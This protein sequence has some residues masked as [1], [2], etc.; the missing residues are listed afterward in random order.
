MA[1]RY[2]Y[3]RLSGGGLPGTDYSVFY[4][5][6][7]YTKTLAKRESNDADADDLTYDELTTANNGQGTLIYTPEF[8]DYILIEDNQT[9]LGCPPATSDIGNAI[10][11]S[12]DATWGTS[13]DC[14]TSGSNNI[15]V[16]HDGSG[17]IPPARNPQTH[18]KSGLQYTLPSQIFLNPK[19]T[20]PLLKKAGYHSLSSTRGNTNDAFMK[21]DLKG[22]VIE[23]GKCNFCYTYRITNFSNISGTTIGYDYTDC[24]TTN[25]ASDTLAPG[26]TI[27]V[28]SLTEPV[29]TTKKAFARVENLQYF[30]D[31]NPYDL[32][33][34]NVSAGDACTATNT[35]YYIDEQTFCSSTNIYTNSNCS[36]LASAGYY[37]DGNFVRYWDGTAFTDPCYSCGAY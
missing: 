31:C 5:G 8:I 11:T 20:K 26:Q 24:D 34:S 33:Y 17:S 21:I 6:S 32:K 29:L 16:W 25:P 23:S 14:C 27:N 18:F 4:S 30:C 3:V 19:I 37:S 22:I 36:T 9:G 13:Q 2:F 10:Y 15:P 12:F 28:C 35:T 7:S 1:N